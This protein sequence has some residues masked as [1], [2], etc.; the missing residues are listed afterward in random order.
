MPEE[1]RQDDEDLRVHMDSF[2]SDIL[3][4]KKM[5]ESGNLEG[6]AQ[7]PELP[8]NSEIARRFNQTKKELLTL[9]RAV[10]MNSD[11]SQLKRDN[12]VVE[13]FDD[14]TES[15]TGE[16]FLSDFTRNDQV[17][18]FGHM[19]EEAGY[20]IP[21]RDPTFVEGFTSGEAALTNLRRGTEATL[22]VITDMEPLLVALAVMK[23]NSPTLVERLG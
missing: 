7:I 8:G 2:E 14:L 3:N 9:S 1:Q 21:D 16:R 22:G 23:R 10:S 4:L 20:S 6:L 17:E 19:M 5:V 11:P 15:F 12:L 18:A 13:V